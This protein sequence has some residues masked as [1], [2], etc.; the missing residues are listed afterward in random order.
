MKMNKKADTKELVKW[1]VIIAFALLALYW[2]G[3]GMSNSLGFI[4]MLR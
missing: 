2:I 1:L 3:M 4:G